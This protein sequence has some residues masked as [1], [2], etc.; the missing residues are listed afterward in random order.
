MLL[1][2][3]AFTAVI[4]TDR[5]IYNK[6]YLLLKQKPGPVHTDVVLHQQ[7]ELVEGAGIHVSPCLVDLHDALHI[8]RQIWIKV[9]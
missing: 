4:V 2:S 9:R 7:P 6:C 8:I 1:L 3:T 5:Q